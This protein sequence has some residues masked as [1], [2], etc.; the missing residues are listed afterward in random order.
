MPAAALVVSTLLLVTG[1]AGRGSAE[2]TAVGDTATAFFAAVSAAPERACTLLA[3]ATLASLRSD[4]EDCAEAVS[5]AAL[6]GD[7]AATPPEIQVY[8]RDAIVQW[9]GQTLFLARFDDGWRVTA[10]DCEPTGKDLP[11]DCTVEGK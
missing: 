5:G 6:N 4:Q 7:V 8:G 10:A 11:F 2:E 1:C 9:A 3:P